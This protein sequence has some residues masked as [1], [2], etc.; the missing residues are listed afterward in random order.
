[1]G[2]LGRE[3]IAASPAR[4][5]RNAA[6]E[7]ATFA[8]LADVAADRQVPVFAPQ[9]LEQTRGR[10]E[11]RI[12]R[13]VNAVFLE[14]VGRDKRQLVNR[15][16]EFGGHGTCSVGYEADS[17]YAAKIYSAAIGRTRF[18]TGRRPVSAGRYIICASSA[19][20]IRLRIS[21]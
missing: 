3:E 18:L 2:D 11:P 19:A 17:G 21:G 10:P 15:L 4:R 20:S 16:S 5:L 7:F 13:L 14:N 6:A 8:I 9:R 12:E 1:M